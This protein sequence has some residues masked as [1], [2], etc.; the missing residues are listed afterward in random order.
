MGLFDR[1]FS[2]ANTGAASNPQNEQ[3]A[4][5]GVLYGCAA[6]DGEVSDIEIDHF[7]R[8][9]VFKAAF[10]NHDLKNYFKTA[11]KAQRQGGSKTLIDNSIAKIPA[12]NRPVLFA[13]VMDLLLADGLLGDK[14]KE[15]AEYLAGV[16]ELNMP[17]AEKI[18]EVMLIRNTGNLVIIG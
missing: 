1:L 8:T 4:W 2:Q 5:V 11:M 10:K 16:L 9:L 14:E 6:A 12:A 18:I 17:T 15:I 13:V 7:A 3:E